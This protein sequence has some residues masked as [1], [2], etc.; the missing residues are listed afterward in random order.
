MAPESR[1]GRSLA[2]VTNGGRPVP[3]RSGGYRGQDAMDGGG[4]EVDLRTLVDILRR[5]SWMIGWIF[6]L[7]VAAAIVFTFF[8]TPTYR[9]SALLEIGRGDGSVPSV[10]SLF[11]EGDPSEEQLRTNF[12]LLRSETLATRVVETLG[13]DRME[14]FAAD[15][16]ATPQSIVAAFL[17]RLV[18]DPVAES[19]LV[20]VTFSA[21]SPEL[22]ARI[23][24]EVVASFTDLRTEMREEGAERIAAQ[25]EEVGR[26]LEESEEDLRQYAQDHDLP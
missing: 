16:E 11:A 12:E 18:I 1:N 13:L 15:E 19:R 14:E 10:A 9:A 7:V 23:V 2:R 24:N 5:R 26:R 3:A 17:E 6:L 25:V 8:Q 20:R 4:I 22:A 21:T